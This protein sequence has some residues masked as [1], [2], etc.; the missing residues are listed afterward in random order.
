MQV[1]VH[2]LGAPEQRD[3]CAYCQKVAERDDIFGDFFLEDTRK[4]AV[5]PPSMI[6]PKG[7]Q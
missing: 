1:P 7:P 3:D 4:M 6:P 5:R 2:D